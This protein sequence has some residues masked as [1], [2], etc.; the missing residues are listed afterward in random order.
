MTGD[1]VSW[2]ARRPCPLCAAVSV[3]TVHE[4]KYLLPAGHPLDPVV[5][6]VACQGCGF[7]FNDT[8]CSREDYDRYYREISKYADPRLS[9]GSGAAAEDRTRLAATA[10]DIG[11]FASSADERILDIGCGAG[12]RERAPAPAAAAKTPRA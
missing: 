2:N 10:R 9:S 8:P 4:G 6:V 3:R 7:C 5:H 12:G 1:P 11:E